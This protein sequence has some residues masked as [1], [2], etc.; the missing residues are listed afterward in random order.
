MSFENP[1]FS[2]SSLSEVNKNMQRFGKSNGRW[3]KGKSKSY[4][5]RVTKAKPGEVVHHK[6]KNKNNNKP[7]N[8]QKMSAA[9]HNKMHPEKGGDH[10][11]KKR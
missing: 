10:R 6:D 3:A 1:D 7:S 4:R 5:R 9:K 8:F 11:K 2:E